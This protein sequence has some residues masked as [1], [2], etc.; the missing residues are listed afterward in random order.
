M[1]NQPFGQRRQPS[2]AESRGKP[3]ERQR[4]DTHGCSRWKIGKNST[5]MIAVLAQLH[6]WSD[7]TGKSGCLLIAVALLTLFLRVPAQAASLVP[8]VLSVLFGDSPSVS[9]TAPSAGSTLL[10]GNITVSASASDLDGT[11]AKVEFYAG[12][13]LIGTA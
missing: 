5:A 1:W 3:L 6:F 2:S 8:P 13:T 7:R 4:N 9:I 11:I 12:T 10:P